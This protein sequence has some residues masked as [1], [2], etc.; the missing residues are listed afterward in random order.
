MSQQSPTGPSISATFL[1]KSPLMGE[2]I[3]H[4]IW[5]ISHLVRSFLE[6]RPSENLTFQLAEEVRT[7]QAEL[8]RTQQILSGDSAI[9][10]SL[11]SQQK[12]QTAGDLSFFLVLVI[13]VLFW[14]WLKCRSP[15]RQSER[16]SLTD[17]E[18]SSESQC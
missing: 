16:L 3:V 13:L 14:L 6:S 4:S 12:H 2:Q 11:E 10:S 1:L 5:T 15:A 9:V 7:L 17:A 18:G 8:H